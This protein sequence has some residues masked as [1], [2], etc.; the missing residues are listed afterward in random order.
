MAGLLKLST[1]V[2]FSPN[3]QYCETLSGKLFLEINTEQLAI[4]PQR[5]FFCGFPNIPRDSTRLCNKEMGTKECLE[6]QYNFDA[7]LL[8]DQRMLYMAYFFVVLKVLKTFV[9]H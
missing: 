7:P 4:K 9:T 8:V 3:E 5:K 1:F 2:R 6:K